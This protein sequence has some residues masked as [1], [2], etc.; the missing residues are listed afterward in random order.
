MITRTDIAVHF[1]NVSQFTREQLRLE[2]E[3][4]PLYNQQDAETMFAAYV[5]KGYIPGEGTL[6][7][8]I[9][10]GGGGEKNR[11]GPSGH[12]KIFYPVVRRFIASGAIKDFDHIVTVF[13]EVVPHWGIWAIM[14]PVLYAAWRPIED[15]AYMNMVP[16]RTRN[17]GLPKAAARNASWE[18]VTGPSLDVLNPRTIVT[19]GKGASD[20]LG[21]FNGEDR[22]ANYYCI[23]R[24]RGDSGIH[25][26]AKETLRKMRQELAP[27]K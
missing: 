27:K 24:L 16:Y 1:H 15:I 7:I 11:Y 13:P 10:P 4:M 12:D 23:K 25:P 22:A 19:L 21:H 26:E 14:S 18:H 9:N 2:E 8:G 17:D 6:I 5:G 20:M 3:H